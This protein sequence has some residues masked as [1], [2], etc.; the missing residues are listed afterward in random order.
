MSQPASDATPFAVGW[1]SFDLGQY[2]PCDG[3]YCFF[4]AESLPPLTDAP[5]DGTF[6]WL[7]PL[8]TDDAEDDQEDGEDGEDR[9]DD[10][11][12]DADSDEGA[13]M[14]TLAADAQRLGLTLPPAFVSFMTNLA[15]Q[16]RIP[17]CTA[18]EF[19]LPE[20]IVPSLGDGD[21]FL[22]S[23]LHDQQ[24]V[25]L[26]YLYLTPIGDSR[27]VVSPYDFDIAGAD[28]S[29]A[30]TLTDEQRAAVIANTFVCAASFE[31]FLY[32]F[33]LENTI[34]FALDS[35]QPLTAEQQRYVA[36]YG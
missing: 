14:A 33:W 20:R 13:R 4:P 6:R 16:E 22:I 24:D 32:R 31:E 15:L 21:G 25:L 19:A 30:A 17:S 8:S 27:V 26:W 34:W 28:P 35:R 9:F 12:S 36:H 3:T 7:T 29:G 23:F 11:D 1:F 10:A 5:L 2:R 18:C